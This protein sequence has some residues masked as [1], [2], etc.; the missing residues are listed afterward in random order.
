MTPDQ[1]AIIALHAQAV[2][3]VVVWLVVFTVL[4]ITV[5]YI[6]Y[7][8]RDDNEVLAYLLIPFALVTAIGLLS[9]LVGLDSTLLAVVHPEA[10]YT[11]QVT[12]EKAP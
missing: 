9:S 4:I 12:K 10:A 8:V 1:A 7:G 3:H 5:Y 6:D 2:T 11:L